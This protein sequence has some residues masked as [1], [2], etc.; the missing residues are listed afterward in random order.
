MSLQYQYFEEGIE[1]IPFGPAEGDMVETQRSFS[2][3]GYQKEVHAYLETVS[4]AFNTKFNVYYKML[5]ESRTVR[6]ELSDAMVELVFCF[7]P[8]NEL[9]EAEF[10]EKFILPYKEMFI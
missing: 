4:S 6:R 3:T 7:A 8:T 9:D 10:K 5:V 2:V 1:V